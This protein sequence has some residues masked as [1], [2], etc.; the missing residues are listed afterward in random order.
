[1]TTS[2]DPDGEIED[3]LKYLVLH[4]FRQGNWQKPIDPKK[5]A[6]Y[7]SARHRLIQMLREAREI[8]VPVRG[9]EGHYEVSNTGR[10]RS[11][12]GGRRRGIELSQHP[13]NRKGY[14]VVSLVKDGKTQTATVH[15][16]VASAFISNPEN[17]PCVN[18][19]DGIKQN[20]DVTNLEWVTY[21]ENELH[22][23]NTLGKINGQAKLTMAQATE[24]RARLAKGEMQE[25][26]AKD[27]GVDRSLI[28]HIKRNL[29]WTR[30][31][32]K[33]KQLKE[34]S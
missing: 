14:R 3:V 9:A 4:A 10:V 11:V 22:A 34:K 30:P 16:L 20:N 28:S 8:F 25:D 12:L 17:K 29:L 19:K 26:I 6:A 1:M 32:L 21:Q 33:N 2:L 23:F 27:Y 7:L 18:H 5:D 24:I 13:R 31:V 15:R